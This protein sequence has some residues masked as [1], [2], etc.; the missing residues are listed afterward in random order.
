M[1]GSPYPSA[2]VDGTRDARATG[3]SASASRSPRYRRPGHV[4]YTVVAFAAR[5][6]G[7]PA[8]AGALRRL[9]ASLRAQR[10]RL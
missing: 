1:R 10:P 8:Y 6:G 2:R 3:A 7:V 5:I 9:L 4:T